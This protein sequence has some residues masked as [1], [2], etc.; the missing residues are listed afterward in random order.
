MISRNFLVASAL[1]LGASN[2]LAQTAVTP[3]AG[4]ANPYAYALSSTNEAGV[5]TVNYSLNADAVGVSL[6]VR[7][8]ERTAVIT[9]ELDGVTKGS[10]STSFDLTGQ[11]SSCYTWEIQVTGDEKTSIGEFASWKFYH[12]SGIDVDNSMESP[13]FGTLFVANGNTTT[14][15]GYYCSANGGAG[16]YM[17]TPDGKGILNKVS[18]NYRFYSDALTFDCYYNT[19]NGAD[20]NRVAI[21]EDGRI[22]VCRHN[23]SGDYIL[24][25]PSV[26]QL[27]TD[28]K[29]TSLVNG[30]TMNSKT[31][32]DD[33]NGNFL[34]GTVQSFDVKGSGE[35]TKIVAITRESNTL[36]ANASDNRVVEYNIGTASTLTEAL[37][38]S[39][40]DG[41][42]SI[43]YIRQANLAYDKK[44][45]IWYAQYRG[46]PSDECPALVYVDEN[47]EQKYFEGAG[48]KVRRRGGVSVSEDGKYLA[49][50]ESA[51]T[52]SIYE[53]STDDGGYVSLNEIYTVNHGMGKDLYALAWDAAGNLFASNTSEKL[54]KGF[55]VPRADNTFTTKAAAQYSICYTAPITP[56][57]VTGIDG[58]WSS[59]TP[60]E[61]DY[62]GTA[63]VLNVDENT[64][65]FKISTTKGTWP[66]FNEGN[67]AVDAAITNGGTVNISVNKNAGNIVLPWAGVWTVTIAK[68]FSTLTAV[69]ETPEPAPSYPEA[70]YL[71]GYNGAWDPAAPLEITGKNGIYKIEAVEFTN[72]TF[73]LSTAKGSWDADFNPNGLN[74]ESNPVAIGQK[75]T[76]TAGFSSNITISA[77]GTYDI[78]ID[79][80]N[81]T[82]LLEGSVSYPDHIYVIGHVGGCNW[83]TADGVALEH[84][85]DGVYKGVVTVDNSGDGYG[86]FQFATVLGKD[87]NAVNSGTR[88]GS[89]VKD[90][91][92]VL[93]TPTTMTN[94]WGGGSLSW[95]LAA[96]KYS[97]YVDIVNCTVKV[98][99]G[100][101][102][103]IESVDTE[104]NA[105]PVYYNLQGVEVKNPANG[106]YIVKRGNKISKETIIK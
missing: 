60:A 86:Y 10:H 15:E 37:P 53:I 13:S 93:D 3:E 105:V 69:T 50:A 28:S 79:L 101:T 35:S 11:E 22:F 33:T 92:I 103:G 2:V 77:A 31:S 87:W 25:A 83:N 90:A 56:L 97:M 26:E 106:L 100:D 75:V 41:K 14:D 80:A 85:E 34:L 74:V 38:V 54:V 62:N 27:A 78:T 29:F 68:D 61:I 39:A 16:L 58:N 64:T 96:D 88:Y 18:N 48:G 9:R 43:D 99:E 21:A 102:V 45:G 57:Y 32:Y 7:N 40:L 52:F 67:L 6:V 70:V 19:A 49:V 20:F 73:K 12:P 47:G 66:E 36:T 82:L 17:F 30:L 59:D 51:T 65:E 95:K 63:Y 8:Q 91:D 94:N 98:E 1:L 42:Y 76:L 24:S 72:T 84:T 5:I 81:N 44:G 55:S 104:E 46:T 23:D 4:T 71:V 89:P